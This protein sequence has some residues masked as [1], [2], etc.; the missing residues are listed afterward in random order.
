MRREIVT[1]DSFHAAAFDPLFTDVVDRGLW[2][3]RRY[4]RECT[5]V[6]G[7]YFGFPET[8]AQSYR[9]LVGN[10]NSASVALDKDFWDGRYREATGKE[11]TREGWKEYKKADELH[12]KLRFPGVLSDWENAADAAREEGREA[13]RQGAVFYPV[14][15]FHTHPN[16]E[17]PSWFP[18]CQ[19][20]WNI[21]ESHQI[22]A[23]GLTPKPVGMIGSAYKGKQFVTLY[24]Q[25]GRAPEDFE[26]LLRKYYAWTMIDHPKPEEGLGQTR[27]DLRIPATFAIEAVPFD[28]GFD[29]AKLS[30]FPFRSYA[31]Q[32]ASADQ[33][34]RADAH[35]A[36]VKPFLKWLYREGDPQSP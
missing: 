19:D 9:L 13:E 7:K 24:Q 8:L 14:V 22:R 32:A 10:K 36:E 21:S 33:Q 15:S 17:R 28:R 4:G 6:V 1:L 5:F 31:V 29:F 12:Q 27:K 2:F 11:R 3:T 34:A 16:Q 30:A 23:T 18:S 25:A 26:S 35:A 20:L